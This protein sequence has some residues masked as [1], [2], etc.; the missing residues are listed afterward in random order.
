MGTV[1][2]KKIKK[3]IDI[4]FLKEPNTNSGIQK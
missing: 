4:T 1:S 3:E 2:H